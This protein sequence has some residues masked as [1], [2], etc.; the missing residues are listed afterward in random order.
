[1]HALFALSTLGAPIVFFPSRFI[2][3]PAFVTRTGLSNSWPISRPYG[4]GWI[5]LRSSPVLKQRPRRRPTPAITREGRGESSRTVL[6]GSRGRSRRVRPPVRA[7]S[8]L[9][10]PPPFRRFLRLLGRLALCGSPSLRLP[11]RLAIVRP[12]RLDPSPTPHGVSVNQRSGG[13]VFVQ[14]VSYRSRISFPNLV[15]L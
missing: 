5:F 12:M 2:R 8:V 3:E 6:V 11:A 4:A 7:A 13:R 14:Q 15:C 9:R 10:L 1:M